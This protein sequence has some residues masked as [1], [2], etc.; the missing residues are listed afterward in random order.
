VTCRDRVTSRGI[1]PVNWR[2]YAGKDVMNY[3]RLVA[4]ALAGTVVDAVYGFLVYG[5]LLSSEFGRYVEIY[6]PNNAPPIYLL[7][8]FAGIFVAMLAAVFIYA[9]GI[10]STGGAAE[11]A[12]FGVCLGFFVGVLFASISYGTINIGRKLT[13][14]M[15]VAGIVE[16]ILVGT[17]IGAVYRVQRTPRAG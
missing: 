10:E 17:V 8:M 15:A 14:M 16:W 7:T 11:G 13:A 12:R 2:S 5:M 6:R 3:G 9:K 4:A 1:D